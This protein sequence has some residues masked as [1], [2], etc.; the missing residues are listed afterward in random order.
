MAQSLDKFKATFR[1]EAFELL[2]Q[3]EDKLLELETSP[4]EA[5]LIN[6]AFRAIHTVKGSAAMFG[7]DAVSAFAH[8]M[9]TVLDLCRAGKLPITKDLIGL[10]LKGRDQLRR[11]MEFETGV[12]EDIAGESETLLALFKELARRAKGGEA[13]SAEPPPKGSGPE[14]DAKAER[15]ELAPKTYRVT[16]K[17]SSD[18]FKNGTKVLNLVEELA[19]LGQADVFPHMEGLPHLRDLDPEACYAWWEIVVTTSQGENAIRDIF[20]FVEDQ[21]ELKVVPVAGSRRRSQAPRRHPRG[22][23]RGLAGGP[24]RRPRLP[25]E[26]G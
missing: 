4:L 18:I 1:E 5:E 21:A 16:F 3:L 17:P 7:F 11:L 6:A 15:E 13:D 23:R 26:A 25:E 19:G 9:E 24:S 22:S 8:E 14:A 10:A 20:I 12:P 2:T